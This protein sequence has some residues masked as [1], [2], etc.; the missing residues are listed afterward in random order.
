MFDALVYC[1]SRLEPRPFHCVVFPGQVALIST[2]LTQPRTP[3][4]SWRVALGLAR[5]SKAKMASSWP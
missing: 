4:K 1:A 2:C 5:S 3:A